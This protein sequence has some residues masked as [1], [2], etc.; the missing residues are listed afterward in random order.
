MRSPFTCPAGLHSRYDNFTAAKPCRP[1]QAARRLADD[2][3]HVTRLAP[4]VSVEQVAAVFA[5]V[6][7]RPQQF[8]QL[9]DWL[10][11]DADVLRSGSSTA[12]QVAQR[13]LAGLA[14]A[15]ADVALPACLRCGRV[16]PLV[17]LVDGGRVCFNCYHAGRPEPCAGCGRTRRVVTRTTD[18]AAICQ[19][20]RT[21]DPATWQPC[22]RCGTTTPTVTIIDGV[23]VGRCCYVPPGLRC[24]VCGQAKGERPWRTRRPICA[25]CA[26]KPHTPCAACGLDAPVPEPGQ[27]ACCHRCDQGATAVCRACG[28]PTVNRDRDD[29]PRCVDCYQRPVRVCG[30]CGRQRVIVRLAVGDDPELCGVCWHGPIV[31]C[32]SCGLERPCRGERTGLMLCDR[33]QRARR[34]EHRQCAFCGHVRPV[35]AHWPNEP[36][37]VSCYQRH[38]ATTGTCP[39][40]QRHGRLLRHTRGQPTCG[41]CLGL[42]GGVCGRCGA[43]NEP[44]WDRG[45]CRRCSL[46]DRLTDLFGEPATRNTRGLDGIHDALAA[47]PSPRAVLDWLRNPGPRQLLESIATGQLAATHHAFDQLEPS[48]TVEHLRHLLVA[49]SV[50]PPRDPVLANLERWIDDLI[51][52]TANTDHAS[53]LR[54]YA[55]WKILPPLPRP[56]RTRPDHRSHRLQRPPTTPQPRPAARVPHRTPPHTRRHQPGRHRRLAHQHT[57]PHHPA[58]PSVRRLGDPPR[59]D[60]TR[61]LPHHTHRT[62]HAHRHRRPTL[63]HRPPPPQRPRH[64]RR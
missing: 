22:G 14:D 52:H 11:A 37:C 35:Y 17:A 3:D 54:L 15:G 43:D 30:R 24:S 2:I 40:C 19:T 46:A 31:A 21:A 26:A 62:H 34:G 23:R 64:R 53:L 47:A 61:R 7:P 9:H 42:G 39:V 20:C 59:R 57:R 25:D 12:P 56:S 45:R 63:G 18:G 32:D 38:R 5:A 58:N 16:R 13:F 50:L 8:A 27:S 29:R 41:D 33:C 4:G 28:M 49:T 6:A 1:C 48:A 60:P 51:D 10:H 55:R 36:V 44:L